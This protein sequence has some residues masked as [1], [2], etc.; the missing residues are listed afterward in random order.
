MTQEVQSTVLM[1]AVMVALFYFM[2]Y[3]PQKKQAAKR[4]AL[5]DSLEVGAEV[6]TIGGIYGKIT[7][8]D[9]KTATLEVA[10]GTKITFARAA[11]NG[12]V[13]KDAAA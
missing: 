13:A 3:R 11:I 7:A 8:L 6:I 12:K 4:K 2:L 5:L 9:E 1:I 10:P